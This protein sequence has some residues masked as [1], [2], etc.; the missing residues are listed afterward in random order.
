MQQLSLNVRGIRNKD[1]FLCYQGEPMIQTVEE[2]VIPL[3]AVEHFLNEPEHFLQLGGSNPLQVFNV[4]SGSGSSPIE[5]FVELPCQC[6]II[7]RTRP[8]EGRG[9]KIQG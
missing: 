4:L 2:V 7:L 9:R 1:S 6:G 5:K 3:P 8:E